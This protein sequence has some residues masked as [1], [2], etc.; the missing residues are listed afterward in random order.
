MNAFLPKNLITGDLPHDRQTV[1]PLI[2]VKSPHGRLIDAEEALKRVRAREHGICTD[3]VDVGFNL[4]IDCAFNLLKAQ[5]T[6]IE[7]EGSE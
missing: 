7:A 2:E 3:G 5:N 1:C 4:G 6:I